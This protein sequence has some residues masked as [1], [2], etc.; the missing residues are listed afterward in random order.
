METQLSITFISTGRVRMREPMS[1]QPLSNQNTTLRLL[2]CFTGKW[3]PWLP[4]GVFLI[5][6]PDGPV[7]I[8]AGA[9]PRCMEAGY[10][11]TLSYF[12]SILNQ[13]EVSAEDDL[14]SQLASMGVHPR[15]L[16]AIV[17]T[18]LHHDHT[19]ALEDL[20]RDAPN[21]PIHV[22]G[23]H[24]EGFGRSPKYAAMQG[25]A[26]NHWPESFSPT[27]LQFGDRAV[28]PWSRSASITRD[29]CILAVETPGHVPG[30]ISIVVLDRRGH[31]NPETTYL[32]TGDATYNLQ[33]LDKGEPDGI[34]SDPETAFKSLELIKEFARQRD[35][36]VLPSHDPDTPR[37]LRERKIYKPK[38]A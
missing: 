29:G 30:H 31:P 16:Q 1:G 4:I 12:A 8:D 19:G 35:V 11:P 36:V 3:T 5:Q 10:F 23:D 22:S 9:S 7:L 32:L 15:M 21:V 33:L 13:L 38:S 28:G 17:L 25:C 37:L 34:N 24:W 18:H 6:H 26:P 2:R 20:V 14:V 27:L